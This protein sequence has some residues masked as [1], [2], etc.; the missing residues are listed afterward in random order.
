VLFRSDVICQNR[1][2]PPFERRYDPST[3]TLTIVIDTRKFPG[4]PYSADRIFY[5]L[6]GVRK[7][8]AELLGLE[9][10]AQAA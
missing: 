7:V 5:P 3:Q 9:E 2:S 10:L 4:T 6:Q 1:R 8:N